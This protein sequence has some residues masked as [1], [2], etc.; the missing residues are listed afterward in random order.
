MVESP[1]APLTETDG[2][3]PTP[4][5]NCQAS[6]GIP[7][8]FSQQPGGTPLGPEFGGKAGY[9]PEEGPRTDRE[10]VG[11]SVRPNPPRYRGRDSPEPCPCGLSQT[12]RGWTRGS[13]GFGAV[14][15]VLPGP[16]NCRDVLG[17]RFLP[18]FSAAGRSCKLKPAIFLATERFTQW[19]PFV[20]MVAASIAAP[21]R[22]RGRHS[23]RRRRSRRHAK[24][25]GGEGWTH[26]PPRR[27]PGKCRSSNTGRAGRWNTCGP[28]QR[29]TRPSCPT[30][31]GGGMPPS[32]RTGGLPFIIIG[33]PQGPTPPRVDVVVAVH[34]HPGRVG[35]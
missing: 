29:C 10:R 28:P 31:R 15:T 30:G 23:S 6:G 4:E 20:G 3:C 34:P 32:R 17:H 13:G 2:D 16:N 35:Q 5:R 1:K 21:W 14:E 12:S 19:N 9:T 26:G 22:C 11:A 18:P 27:A 33:V 7:T 24:G 8:R 25:D